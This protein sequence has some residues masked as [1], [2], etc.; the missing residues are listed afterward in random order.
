MNELA[1]D[2]L[3][4]RLG[5]VFLSIFLRD[6]CLDLSTETEHEKYENYYPTVSIYGR[7]SIMLK[8][9]LF[10]IYKPGVVNE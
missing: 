9:G 6:D 3:R 2:K 7:D 5:V 1:P 4:I 10:F 8:V